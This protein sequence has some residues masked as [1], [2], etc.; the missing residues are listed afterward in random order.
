MKLVFEDEFTAEDCPNGLPNRS[1]WGY[2][3]G[4]VRNHE[5]QYYTEHNAQ[6]AGGKLVIAAERVDPSPATG[7]AQYTSSSLTTTGLH[8]WQYGLFEMRGKVDVRAGSW[9]AW[10]TLGTHNGWP[11]GG[12]VDI[13][14]YYR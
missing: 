2:E 13:M 9:P 11:K 10:W 6:C 12:E 14:E 8:A 5:A 3:H 1:R 7:N 4:M